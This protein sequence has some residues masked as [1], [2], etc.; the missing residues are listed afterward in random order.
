M[1]VTFTVRGIPVPQGSAKP[2]IAGGRARLAT[3]SAPLAAWRTAIATAASTAMGD[4][5]TMAGPVVVEATF[6][7]SRPASAPRRVTVPAVRPDLDKL[8]RALL[9]GITGVVVK[10]DSLVV[11]LVL[12]KRYGERPGV[13]VTVCAYQDDARDVETERSQRAEKK[14]AEAARKAG[15]A[16]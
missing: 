1:S 10:D 2:F 11:D 13:E 9:D 7:L 15:R 4:A 8:A 6:I 3:K 14:R 12:H 5:P 16:A